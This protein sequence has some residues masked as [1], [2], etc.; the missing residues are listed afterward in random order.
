M[1]ERLLDVF[2]WWLIIAFGAMAFYVVYP[3]YN[4]VTKKSSSSFS[5]TQPPRTI[6]SSTFNKKSIFFVF[7]QGIFLTRQDING[8]II[9]FHFF[10]LQTFCPIKFYA[11]F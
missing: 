3:K 5:I 8:V 2:K 10:I 6:V 4:I 9:L 7:N 1:K 11:P